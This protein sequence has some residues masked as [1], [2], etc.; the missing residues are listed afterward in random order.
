M[1]NSINKE[2]GITVAEAAEI[3]GCSSY[4]LRDMV[5]QKKIPA[6]R[7]GKRILFTKNGISDWIN[8]QEKNNCVNM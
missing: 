8:K 2:T 3:I 4:T 7:V 6:Y 1:V 5:R